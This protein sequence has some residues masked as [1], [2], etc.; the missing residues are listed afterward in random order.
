MR[1]KLAPTV[2]SGEDPRVESAR[3]SVVIPAYNAGAH[4][5]ATLRSVLAQTA[6]PGEIIVVDDGSSDDTV[7]IATTFGVR[8]IARE[9]SG[10]SAARNAGTQAA[11]GEFIAYL[12]ADDLWPPEKLE[13]Q[14]RALLAYPAA[15]FSFTDYRFFDDFGVH[16]RPSELRRHSAFRRAVGSLNGRTTFV[17]ASGE[18]HPVYTDNYI[19]P[20]SVLA[21]KS[22]ILAVGGYDERL[23]LCEDYEFFLRLFKRVPAVAIVKPLV[24]YRRHANQATAQ[25]VAIT[26]GLFDVERC[27]AA[28]PDRYPPADARFILGRAFELHYRVGI[29]HAR[30]GSFPEAIA[31]F[32]ASLASRFTLRAGVAL[33][34]ARL[35]GSAVGRRVFA[36]IRTIWKSRPQHRSLSAPR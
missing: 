22:D 20:S 5:G 31:S 36:R 23:R 14:L 8:V 2:T 21:R 15:A 7:A 19:L 13:T 17:I 10:P 12:D 27:V 4:L 35:A 18:Q 3:I 6:P 26:A 9:N 29:S 1:T 32:R 11:R 34:A 30:L 33:L 28:A 16:V 24:L 25:G